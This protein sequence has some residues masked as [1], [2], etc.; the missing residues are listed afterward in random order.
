MIYIKRVYE[1]IDINKLSIIV[2]LLGFLIFT[3]DVALSSIAGTSCTNDDDC[4]TDEKCVNGTCCSTTTTV[5]EPNSLIGLL[6][7]G[8]LG[9]GSLITRKIRKKNYNK[10][11]EK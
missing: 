9:A 4:S 11:V 7:F 6:T 8:S 2:S 5:P 3:G 10:L 1:H